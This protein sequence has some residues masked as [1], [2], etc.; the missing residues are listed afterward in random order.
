LDLLGKFYEKPYLHTVKN[1]KMTMTKEPQVIQVTLDS[2]VL[3]LNSA[4]PE[5]EPIGEPSGRLAMS[6]EEY[7][8]T[9]LNRNPWAPPNTPPRI[10]QTSAEILLG[11]EGWT[12]PLEH[13]D[14]ENHR[15]NYRLVSKE[16]PEDL[17]LRDGTIHWTPKEK[18]TYE[19]EVEAS[20]TGWP[21]AVT[22][23]KLVFH[24]KDPPPEEP[25]VEP[26]KFDVASQAFVTGLT[27]GRDGRKLW[28]RSRTDGKS[29]TLGEGSEFEL[30]TIKA[31]VI[32]INTKEDYATLETDGI[33][34][35][36]DMETS[37]ADAYR[38]GLED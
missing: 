20:D 6:I 33:R 3:A 27:S 37:L 36:V 15:V 29:F 25:K 23:E 9:I 32:S 2:Q 17:D 4:S 13:E 24:V 12:F 28:I 22:T 5:Q 16:V 21:S 7:K 14:K 19:I 38:K 35:T 1:F 8:D 10:K 31:K 18:G 30:G 26:P 34:W 11:Q